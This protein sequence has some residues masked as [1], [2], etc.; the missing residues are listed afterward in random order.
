MSEQPETRCSNVHLTFKFL[1]LTLIG[2]IEVEVHMEAGS[3]VPFPTSIL[4]HTSTVE[5]TSHCVPDH[6]SQHVGPVS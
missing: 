5:H 3:R 1:R 2:A 6:P 4:G